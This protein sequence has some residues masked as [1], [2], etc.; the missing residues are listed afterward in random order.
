MYNQIIE[1]SEAMR[2]DVIDFAQRLIQTPSI[3]GNEKELAD[4]CIDEMKKLG[5]DEVFR[6]A[7]GNIV[8]TMQ[9]TGG[10]KN[11]MYNS[12]MDHVDA[13][14]LNNWKY[15][16]YKAEIAY[17]FIHG[18]AASDV[19][20]GMAAQIYAG[21]LL[22]KLGKLKGNFIYTG[23]VQEESAELFGI[24]FLCEKTFKEK[25]ITF[26]LMISSESTN[27]DLFLGHRGRVEMEVITNGRTSHGSTPQRGI[28][29]IEKM[30][31]I[32]AGINKIAENLPEHHFLGKATLTSTVINCS[33]GRLSI[34]PDLCTVS[35]DRR[36]VPGETFDDA[37]TP[38]KALIESLKANDKDF[39]AEIRIKKLKQTSYTGYSKEVYKYMDAWFLE[40]DSEYVGMVKKSLNKIGQ[41]PGIGKWEFGTDCSYVTGRLGIPSIGYSPMEEVYAHTP[42]DRVDIDKIIKAVA[43]NASIAYDFCKW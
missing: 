9:G 42:Y 17:G 26:G 38:I 30:V 7:V 36:L 13:G 22:K 2:D 14:N 21:A 6:D 3:S 32:L 4:L 35:L 10:G 16:P 37:M 43:G 20:G 31:P 8:G 12:H 23:V 27:L 18:R 25:D 41:N 5:Y 29:A 11:I 33:P 34:I 28:N 15:D 39:N 1:L 24:E 19:K 40:E